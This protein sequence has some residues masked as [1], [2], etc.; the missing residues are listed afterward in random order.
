MPKYIFT[1]LGCTVAAGLCASPAIAQQSSPPNLPPVVVE[2]KKPKPA[3]AVERPAQN[4]TPAAA[5]AAASPPQE[6]GIG[7][8]GLAMPLSGTVVSGPG[9]A[10]GHPEAS[11]VPSLLSNAAPGVSVFQNGG[12]AGLPV[13]DGL[14]DDRL[15]VSNGMFTTAACPNHMNPTLSFVAPSAIGSVEITNGTAPVSKGGD[16]IGGTISVLSP[17]PNFA[18]V[19]GELFKAVTLSSFY[20]S[21][22]NGVGGAAIAE[23]A[24]QNFSIKY[25]GA[26]SRAEDYHSGNNGPNVTRPCSRLAIKR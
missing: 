19:P 14:A 3:K 24:T 13:V 25:T 11:D 21:N 9:L 5:E 26:W 17:P 23:A 22:G 12:V 7:T 10:A 20:R 6:T 1:V 2:Q 18:A 16:N 15:S 4:V 8:Q